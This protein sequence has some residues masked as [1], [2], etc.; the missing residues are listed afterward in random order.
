MIYKNVDL[1][2]TYH[3]SHAGCDG[4]QKEIEQSENEAVLETFVQC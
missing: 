2:P 3:G 1:S 4:L